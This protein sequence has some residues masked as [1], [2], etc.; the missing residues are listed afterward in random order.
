MGDLELSCFLIQNCAAH[1]ISRH[2]LILWRMCVLLIIISVK[3]RKKCAKK[4]KMLRISLISSWRSS[5]RIA[6]SAVYRSA[7]VGFKRNF[8][9]LSTVCA[10]C[11]VHLSLI[12]FLYST[13]LCHRAQKSL[14]AHVSW[15]STPF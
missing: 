3:G 15:W 13:P 2:M 8:A 14:S 11:L 10:D 7:S 1:R 6:F 9:F 4:T 12:H 5:F